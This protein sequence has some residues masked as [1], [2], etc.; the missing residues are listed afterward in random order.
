MKLQRL[1]DYVFVLFFGVNLFFITYIVDFEQIAIRDPSNFEYPRWPPKR[2][3]LC[4]AGVDPG[5]E[6]RV[7]KRADHQRAVHPERGG[8]WGA[9]AGELE[10]C[11][12]AEH[13]VAGDA[14]AEPGADAAAKGPVEGKEQEG[15]KRV[16]GAATGGAEGKSANRQ[17]GEKQGKE[18]ELRGRTAAAVEVCAV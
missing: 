10:T 6:H 4:T 1:I 14:G 9:Q 8:V 3:T 11:D 17:K 7:V 15:E 16:V 2:L 13:A 5:C 12:S 18:A